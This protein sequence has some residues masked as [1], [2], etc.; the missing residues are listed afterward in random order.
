MIIL[1][2]RATG[3]TVVGLDGG[4]DDY[5]TKPFKFEEL[6][7]RLRVRLRGDQRVGADRPPRRRRARST[8]ARGR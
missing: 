5:V 3:D 1:T 8:S 6:L 2:A 7:A 4:A